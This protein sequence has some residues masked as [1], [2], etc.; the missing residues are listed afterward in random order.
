MR[1]RRVAAPSR[2]P[3]QIVF[4]AREASHSTMGDLMKPSNL[5]SP[6]SMLTALLAASTSAGSAALA[7][8][9]SSDTPR[10]EVSYE[11][12]DLGT[13]EGRETLHRQIVAAARS[14]CPT[15]QSADVRLRA[16]ARQ[17]RARAIDAAVRSVGNAELTALHAASGNRG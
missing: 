2:R 9:A 13:R 4:D 17:C 11:H 16:L 1:D 8:P 15:P 12:L 3:A 7:A 6:G 14:V 5:L 10:I